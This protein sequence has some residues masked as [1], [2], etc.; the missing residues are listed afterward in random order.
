MLLQCPDFPPFPPLHP[1]PPTPSVSPHNIVHVHGSCVYVLRL[2]YFLYCTL[3][4]QGYSVT[5]Y[6]F[7]LIPSPLHPFSPSPLTSGNYLVTN[8]FSL[9]A[10]KPLS[11][12]KRFYFI[13]LQTEGKGGRKRGRETSVWL[14]RVPPTGDMACNPGMCPDWEFNQQ[15]LW[16]VGQCSIH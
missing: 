8:F 14:P 6:L 1:V 15:P 7:F 13:Y 12:L 10:F 5:T 3:H 11:F 4:S 2:L 16:L 9:T